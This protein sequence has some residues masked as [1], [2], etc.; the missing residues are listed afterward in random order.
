MGAVKAKILEK[1]ATGQVMQ[2]QKI[3][4]SEKKL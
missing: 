4:S 3:I 2:L 1:R